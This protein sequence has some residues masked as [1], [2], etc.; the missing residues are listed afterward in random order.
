MNEISEI[1]IESSRHAVWAALTT[2][3]FVKRWQFGATLLTA[4]QV[5]GEIRFRSEWEGK[6]FE[7]WGTVLAFEPESHIR[8]SLFAPRPGLE[9][10][11]ENYF[12]MDYRLE[13][14]DGGVKLLIAQEDARPRADGLQLQKQ[15]GS[16]PVLT[17]LKNL[18]EGS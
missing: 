10:L 4:W 12:I 18:V 1:A 13:E 14:S 15:D 9:D 7:Q 6:V 17:A 3:E 5:G 11:P 2:P 8:Y 16:N